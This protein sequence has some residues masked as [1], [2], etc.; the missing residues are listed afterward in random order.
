MPTYNLK[1]KIGAIIYDLPRFLWSMRPTLVHDRYAAPWVFMRNRKEYLAC[2]SDKKGVSCDWQ[3]TSDLHIAKVFPVIGLSFM[4]KALKFW[5]IAFETGPIHHSKDIDISFIIGHRGT[6]R[7]PHLLATIKSIAAQRDVSVECIVVEQSA[8]PEIKTQLPGWVRYIHTPLPYPDMPYCR[9]WAFNVGARAAKG[10]VLILH[11]NDMLVPQDYALEIM[12]RNAEGYEVTNL[13]RFIFFLTERH[14][15][16][17]ISSGTLNIAD[18][19][20]SIMQNAEGGGSVAISKKAYFEI[21]GFDEA[22]IGWGGED[23]EFW[24][25]A[26]T[27]KVWP[28][29]YLPLLHLWHA[30]QAGKHKLE[31]RTAALL[32]ERS[33]IPVEARIKELSSRGFG[34]PM[35]LS[36]KNLSA[37]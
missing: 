10:G 13:K 4:K 21:G 24:E 28:F 31:R 29:G 18:A 11:D 22:F 3:W 33:I 8:S 26:Q 14:S 36:L 17:I 34:D 6:E 30:S 19:P 27:R 32:E 25:R 9:S 7:L 2:S 16:S 37:V 15:F 23:N 1:Q 20:Q 5:P 12:K 35:R